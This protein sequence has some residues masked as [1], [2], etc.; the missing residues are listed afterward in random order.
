MMALLMTFVKEDEMKGR[1]LLDVIF[2][3]SATVLELRA[4]KLRRCCSTGMSSSPLVFGFALSIVFKNPIL[5]MI[6]LPMTVCEDAT[7]E[8]IRTNSRCQCDTHR[9][10]G[11][12][13]RDTCHGLE[14]R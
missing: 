14:I 2:L 4:G 12:T 1:L 3:K 10:L 9:N 6:A 7:E 5:T 11:E 13:A 8:S